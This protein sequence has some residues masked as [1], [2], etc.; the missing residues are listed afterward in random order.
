MSRF[1][2]K[3]VN[4]TWVVTR[5]AAGRKLATGQEAGRE[6]KVFVSDIKATDG[7]YPLMEKYL[8][9]YVVPVMVDGVVQ[10]KSTIWITRSQFNELCGDLAVPLKAASGI[11]VSQIVGKVIA[12]AL[13]QLR[14][15]GKETGAIGED[16][17]DDILRTILGEM[18]QIIA[19]FKF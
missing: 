8:L 4:E 2:P 11:Q 10:S 3:T 19:S 14:A 5:D 16:L 15:Q 9:P 12:M 17:L 13:T 6:V 7:F 18:P 1:D